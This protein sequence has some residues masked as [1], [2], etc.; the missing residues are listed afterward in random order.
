M[1]H[2]AGDFPHLASV[3]ANN[4]DYFCFPLVEML[5]HYTVTPSIKPW[6]NGVAS[7]GKLNLRRDL[8]WVAKRTRKFPRKLA[9]AA[10]KKKHFKA[11]KGSVPRGEN[12]TTRIDVS[13]LVLTCV[14]LGWVAK[15]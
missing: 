6:S 5:V 15:R 4:Q 14:D 10:K 7:S 9:Q 13:H 8:G 11:N 3:A 12:V 2:T 1:A